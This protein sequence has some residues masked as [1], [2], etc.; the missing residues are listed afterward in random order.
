[1]AADATAFAHRKSLANMLKFVV[2]PLDTDSTPHVDYIRKYWSG[3]EGYTDGWYT[4][5]VS[6]EAQRLLNANY[7][8]NYE[9][10][11]KVKKQY[12]PTNLFRLNANIDP[13]A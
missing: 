7:Q 5:E 6:D 12:D 13:L 9:R 4:N 10:L 2:W 8:G 1:V 3:V 11:L